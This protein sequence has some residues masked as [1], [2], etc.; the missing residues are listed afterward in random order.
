V[1]RS[2]DSGLW[3]SGIRAGF[4][5]GRHPEF[6][7]TITDSRRQRLRPVCRSAG[8]VTVGDRLDLRWVEEAEADSLLQPMAERLKYIGIR[9]P[10]TAALRAP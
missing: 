3:G 7:F 10:T 5:A 4:S 1:L 6:I 8:Y 2:W 9:P